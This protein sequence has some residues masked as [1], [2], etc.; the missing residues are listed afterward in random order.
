MLETTIQRFAYLLDQIPSRI[1]AINPD[2]FS[3]KP[4]PEKWS[5]K[6]I[7]GH[8]IDSAA[9]N[10][11]RFI[12]GQFEDSPTVSYDQDEWV[13]HNHYQALDAEHVIR[14]WTLF[15]THLLEIIRRVPA[16]N[17]QRTCKLKDGTVQTLQFLIEDYV[18]HM[19][20]HLH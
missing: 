14:L 11:Q 1:R 12:R 7:L 20:H 2:I 15:N 5:K 17:L 18:V 19:E 13:K 6:E 10:Q 3:Q 4:A 16:E 9:N 8:L